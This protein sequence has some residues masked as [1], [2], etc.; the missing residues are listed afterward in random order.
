MAEPE[1]GTTEGQ[2]RAKE[3]DVLSKV[4]R[5][6]QELAPEAQQRLLNAVVAF[7]GL[8]INGPQP[9]PALSGAADSDRSSAPRF[10]DNRTPTPKEFV[11]DKRPAT[12]V[13]RIACLAYYSTH[14][15]DTPHFKTLD[16]SKLNT[17]A[18]QLKFSNAAQAVDNATKAG[19]LVP[20]SKGSKQLSKIGELY[21]QALPDREAARAAVANVRPK[22][23]RSRTGKGTGSD[24]SSTDA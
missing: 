15:L 24:D 3:T 17:D 9:R 14:Y 7:L 1:T 8:Q 22:R 10:S 13:E 21:V 20:A 6:F 2:D 5:A 4:V 23:R 11:F 18:A 12:D 16:L 19:F